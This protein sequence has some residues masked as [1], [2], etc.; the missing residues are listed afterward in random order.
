MNGCSSPTPIVAASLC[1]PWI[2][3]WE[4]PPLLKDA[5]KSMNMDEFPR[6]TAFRSWSR[7]RPSRLNTMAARAEVLTRASS[8][9]P[10]M[11]DQEL[12]R[13]LGSHPQRR[14]LSP[15][16]LGVKAGRQTNRRQVITDRRT[17]PGWSAVMR[18]ATSEVVVSRNG[19]GRTRS[20]VFEKRNTPTLSIGQ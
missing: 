12:A 8:D 9:H 2:G 17:K 15:A 14:E 6:Q 1:S 20:L 7:P 11:A 19:S 3:S 18:L 4:F 16:P 5:R 10:G 13:T